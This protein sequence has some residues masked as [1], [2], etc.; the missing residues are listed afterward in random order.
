MPK[1]T[2]VQPG[3]WLACPHSHQTV[4][5]AQA[6]LGKI[7]SRHKVRPAA[8]T[9]TI[10]I[11]AQ[12]RSPLQSEGPLL[13]NARNLV[14]YIVHYFIQQPF[15]PITGFRRSFGALLRFGHA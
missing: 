9:Q 15:F 4:Y 3:M 10:D 12:T 11:K 7:I 14:T 13:R 8:V 5:S 6:D 1:A 2:A